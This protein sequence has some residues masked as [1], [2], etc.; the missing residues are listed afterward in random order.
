MAAEN[1]HRSLKVKEHRDLQIQ[2]IRTHLLPALNKQGF[3]PAPLV[4]RGSVDRESVLGFP[5][6]QLIRA[7]GAGVDLVEIQFASHRRAAFRINAGVAPKEGMMTSTGHW[8]A[9]EVCVQWL[10]EF[11]EMYDSP[12]WRIWFSLLF[13]R[14]RMPVQVDYDKLALR[15][16]GLLPEVELALREGKLGPHMRKIVIPRRGQ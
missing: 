10:T 3:E 14:F 8:P 4:Q 6:G 9:E 12:R 15:V 13:W 2:S 5:L 16:A 7:R 1:R 11:F